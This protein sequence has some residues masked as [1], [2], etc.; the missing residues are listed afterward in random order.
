MNWEHVDL[1]SG[2]VS[3]ETTASITPPIDD[4]GRNLF[5]LPGNGTP[6]T[7]VAM[8]MS[9]G[10]LPVAGLDAAYNHVLPSGVRHSVEYEQPKLQVLVLLQLLVLIFIQLTRI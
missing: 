2:D 5:F 3:S 1:A 7:G 4:E 10:H 6:A 8:R 9:N